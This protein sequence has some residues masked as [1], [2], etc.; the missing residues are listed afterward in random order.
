MQFSAR[1]H[2]GIF[3]VTTS[4]DAN[5]QGFSDFVKVI[6]EHEEWKPGGRILCDHT[7]LN[8]GPLT[9]D[10]VQDIANISRKYKAQFGNAK[11]ATLVSRD[12]EYGMA[13]MWEVFVESEVW[14]ASEELFRDRDNAVAWLS[15]AQY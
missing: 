12:L 11:V 6:F 2:D 3:E 8:A 5:L 13:R 15:I 7:E 4:G 9:V 10:D 1:Y 14:D